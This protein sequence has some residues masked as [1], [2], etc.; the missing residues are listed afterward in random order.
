MKH[1]KRK[2][3]AFASLAGLA[4]VASV[5]PVLAEEAPQEATTSKVGHID[6]HVD[7]TR[8]DN[9][10]REAA[11]A[12]IHVYQ[13]ETE[14]MSGDDPTEVRKQAEAYYDQK[15]DEVKQAI[16]KYLGDKSEHDAHI[17]KVAGIETAIRDYEAT[18]NSRVAF[19]TQ[20]DQGNIILNREVVQITSAE[21]VQEYVTKLSNQTRE[22]EE[23]IRTTQENNG[24]ITNKPTFTLYDLVVADELRTASVTEPVAPH[25]SF[26][27]LDVRATP[28]AEATVSNKDGAEILNLE[29][30]SAGGKKVVQAL[31]GQTVG[32]AAKSNVLPQGRYDKIQNVI[33]KV[34]LPEGVTV[35][36][37]MKQSTDKYTVEFNEAENSLTYTAKPKY[38][39]QINRDQ[40]AGTNGMASDFTLD[41]PS[42]QFTLPEA[43]KTYQFRTEIIVNNEYYVESDNITI[44]TDSATPEKHNH[45]GEN[46]TNIDGKA[47]FPG[48]IN[49]YLVTWDF[50][51]YKGVNVDRE[52][53]EKGLQLVD[54]YDG[55]KLEAVEDVVLYDGTNIIGKAPATG[56]QFV[57]NDGQPIEGLT[58]TAGEE[59][60]LKTLTIEYKKV[61]GAF[62]KQYVE[63]GKQLHALFKMKTLAFKGENGYGGTYANQAFQRDFGN[64]S[65]AKPTENS[66]PNINPRKDAV[67]SVGDVSSLDIK[68]NPQS[69]VEVGTTVVYRVQGSELPINTVFEGERSY[70]VHDT[71]HAADRYDGFFQ[72]FASNDIHFK[73]GTAM[74]NRYK[75]NGG[76]MKAGTE[77]TRFA[78]QVITRQ[79]NG[80]S[81]VDVTLDPDFIEQ[82]DFEKT[83]FAVDTYFHATR[84]KN[85]QGV[86]NTA[87][88]VL[89]GQEFQSTTVT[90][91]SRLNPLANV[92]DSIK[93]IEDKV[94]K[95]TEEIKRVEDET[96]DAFAKVIKD[97]LKNATAINNLSVR[98]MKVEEND[99]AQDA[100]VADH[101]TKLADQ[102]AKIAD[103]GAKVS[104]HSEAIKNI[105]AKLPE[106]AKPS[107]PAK[108]AEPE[109]PVEKPITTL[110]IYAPS[111]KT[112]SDARAF[113]T[114]AG[115]AEIQS[116]EKDANGHYV[117]K[118]VEGGAIKAT[119][120]TKPEAPKAEEPKA[121]A[122]KAEEPKAD[123]PKA[124]EPKAEEPKA[125]AP[126]KDSAIA[127]APKAPEKDSVSSI[128]FYT[129]K[130]EEGVR[131]A[132]EAQGVKPEDIVSVELIDGHYVAKIK[133]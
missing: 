29:K 124:E 74:Y 85:E 131:K 68:N 53:Q 81:R 90:T 27:Y 110:V 129:I 104:D 31:K 97:V 80:I 96:T 130:S 108:P 28:N 128:V 87:Y 62:Y 82:I 63:G 113:A 132:L 2:S 17:K 49:R 48:T 92:A 73:E 127:E 51:Q 39:V 6:I 56:G 77:L 83:T 71:F 41:T 111:V 3:V 57:D 123:A 46:M 78:S 8:L 44:R 86:T 103:Q 66:I 76:V 4:G 60:G 125:E 100:K 93:D 42:V 64:E 12:G 101:G 36:D 107:E 10:V 1:I 11:A 52:M 89:H 16:G 105:L 115:A 133:E 25:V 88:E 120:E 55:N 106:P 121:D 79:G 9:A 14:I 98:V 45:A 34:Y 5:S 47:V 102:D 13:T 37:S 116:V 40:Q 38:L 122:P 61:D 94:K 26:H 32:V 19:Q 50:D 7:H 59:D 114:Q 119:P 65:V 112:E 109:K 99:K 118:Y 35:E 91:N 33:Y 58:L 30:E 54:K 24:A 22:L 20:A 18:Q 72:Q 23:F 67:A 126:A 43:D 15:T 69:S 21:Q 70:A 95:N 75:R 84:V 117:V